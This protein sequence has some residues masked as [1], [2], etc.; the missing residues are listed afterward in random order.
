VYFHGVSW[1]QFESVL[2]LRG[3]CGDVRVTYVEGELELMSP[4]QQ[5]E[6][7]KKKLAR[8]I[9]AF[10]EERGIPLEGYGSWTIKNQLR[11][12]GAEPD[13]CYVVGR[14]EGEPERPHIAI[15]VVHTTGGID[16]LSVY[17][18]LGVPEV[19]FF[20]QGQ[21]ALHRLEDEG[22]VVATQSAFLPDLDVS[23]IAR[24][25]KAESQTEALRQLR[26]ALQA[27]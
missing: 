23:L 13:E 22:Y 26:T 19:W 2:S 14:T 10:A 5:H 6:L 12:R 20:Q 15:E 8:L 27:G 1:P 17:R 11:Q 21:L 7:I 3:D 16:K 18:G 24:C 9:E 25:M 4:S